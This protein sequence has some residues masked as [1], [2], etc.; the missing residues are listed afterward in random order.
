VTQEHE[1]SSRLTAVEGSS[2]VLRADYTE[3]LTPGEKRRDA[4]RIMSNNKYDT[5]VSV[6]QLPMSIFPLGLTIMLVDGNC[7]LSFDGTI[8]V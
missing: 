2:F 7:F 4:F 1:G 5:H 3:V 8:F 6:S